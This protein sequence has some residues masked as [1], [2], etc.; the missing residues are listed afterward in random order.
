[1][2]IIRPNDPLVVEVKGGRLEY[3]GHTGEWT[4]TD[5]NNKTHIL[6]KD[7]VIQAKDAH[8]NLYRKLKDAPLT[9]NF[10]F[11][12]FHAVCFPDT[13]IEKDIRLDLPIDIIIDKPRILDLEESISE[14]FKYWQKEKH[15]IPPQQSGI[16]SLINLLAPQITVRTYLGSDIKEQE[17]QIKLLTEEQFI[18]LDMLSRERKAIIFGCAGSGKTL[19]A[20]EKAKRLA[21]EGYSVLFTCFNS[22]LANW[23]NDKYGHLEGITISN[24]HKL[25]I[26]YSNR[27]GIRI[28]SINSE[29]VQGDEKYYYETIIPQS[30]IDAISQMGAQ[31]NAII[32]DEGQD[33]LDSWWVALDYLLFDPNEDVFYIFCDDNQNIYL[34]TEKNYLFQSPSIVLSKNC[35]TTKKIHEVIQKYYQGTIDVISNGPIGVSPEFIPISS[36]NELL[37]SY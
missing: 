37:K 6:S 33:F 9:A 22:R 20:I 36:E 19:L 35:R 10:N 27:A 21:N 31:H 26:D 2:A 29:I 3:N 18:A 32:V 5:R 7:P 11:P 28:P 14:I 12:V 1:M 34:G 13:V 25:C 23:L 15:L 24:F 16:N 30:L 8:Y 17:E 4:T